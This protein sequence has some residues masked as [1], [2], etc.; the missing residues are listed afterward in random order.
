VGESLVRASTKLIT[1]WSFCRRRSVF[2]TYSFPVPSWSLYRG[3]APQARRVL[4][5]NSYRNSSRAS[6][7][8]SR[9]QTSSNR[10]RS[11]Q[12]YEKAVLIPPS[13]DL[14]IPRLVSPRPSWRRLIELAVL[15]GCISTVVLSPNTTLR[16]KFVILEC[17]RVKAQS[18]TTLLWSATRGTESGDLFGPDARCTLLPWVK[19]L[20]GI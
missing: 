4:R 10:R 17:C 7:R 6:T 14:I 13:S 11:R 1:V 9:R 20:E 16:H 15:G 5:R 2:N 3:L 19:E 8:T 12:I 18:A